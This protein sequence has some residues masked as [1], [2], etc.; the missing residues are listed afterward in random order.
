MPAAG[1]QTV[2][3]TFPSLLLVQMKG[4]GIKP[5]RKGLDLGGI[6]GVV[7]A[8]E[9]LTNREVFEIKLG[10]RTSLSSDIYIRH[11]SRTLA[12]LAPGA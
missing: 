7:S 9:A 11:Q 4:L 3:E 1:G 2:E 8:D 6:Q 10:H 5:G 12:P